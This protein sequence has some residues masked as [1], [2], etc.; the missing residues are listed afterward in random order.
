M[1]TIFDWELIKTR[2]LSFMWSLLS[3]AGTALTAMLLSP[4]F[5]NIVTNNFG[6]GATGMLILMVVTELVKHL[7]NMRAL[8]VGRGKF[9]SVQLARDNATLI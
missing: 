5:A 4:D 1:Q 3:L 2:A 9:G 6:T 7:R 8:N